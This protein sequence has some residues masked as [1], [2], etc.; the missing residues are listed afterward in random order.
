MS[1]VSEDEERA[2]RTSSKAEFDSYTPTPLGDPN[3]NPFD[4]SFKRGKTGASFPHLAPAAD[5]DSPFS[6]RVPSTYDL[7]DAGFA[8]NGAESFIVPGEGPGVMIDAVERKD[9]SV[10]AEVACPGKPKL[11]RVLAQEIAVSKGPIVVACE[12]TNQKTS[13]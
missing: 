5:I 7:R 8:R 13:A 9:L 3:V 4:A 11:D 2:Q 6:S 12:W 1:Y 10:V